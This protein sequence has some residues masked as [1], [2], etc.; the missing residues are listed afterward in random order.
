[1][2]IDRC[3]ELVGMIKSRWDG[4]LRRHRGR[5]RRRGVL[6]RARPS[7]RAVTAREARAARGLGADRARV[8]RASASTAA[9]DAGGA[10]RCAST[11]ASPRPSGREMF[12]IALT[13]Q[14][15][16][17]PARREHD[18]ETRE[19]LVDLFGE[20]ER[21]AGHHAPLPVGARHDARPELHRSGGLHAAR[22]VVVR[23][24]AR[25]PRILLQPARRRRAA[26]F[27]FSGSILHRG[28]DG[29]MQVVLVPWSCS[30]QWSC[31]SRRGAG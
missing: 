19:R 9:E 16:V 30:A 1:M 10:A 17:E 18:A 15:N 28:D 2:P 29:R 26:R 23:P 5:R 31:R 14:I 13:A 25:P 6:R 21:W 22:A 8:R 24:R 7:G 27:H 12:T 11:S 4:H 3:Y 20:P